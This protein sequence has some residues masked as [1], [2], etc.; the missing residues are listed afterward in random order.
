MTVAVEFPPTAATTGVPGLLTAGYRR[1]GDLCEALTVR[2]QD[3]PARRLP[4]RV[5]PEPN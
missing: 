4:K 3:D 1:L 5:V 2:V